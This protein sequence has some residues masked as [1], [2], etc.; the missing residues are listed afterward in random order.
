[1]P[2]RLFEI[3]FIFVCC[4]LEGPS[5]LKSPLPPGVLRRELRWGVLCNVQ[6]LVLLFLWSLWHSVAARRW[7]RLQLQ[8]CYLGCNC[9]RA[10][11]AYL[12][13]RKG[14]ALPQL[15]AMSVLTSY[16]DAHVSRSLGTVVSFGGL[17]A[18]STM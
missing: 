2:L 9:N 17:E 7:E 18:C 13:H 10:S 4:C 15:L 8:S 6:Q 12:Q 3:V 5:Y 16:F 11:L 1:M 14:A